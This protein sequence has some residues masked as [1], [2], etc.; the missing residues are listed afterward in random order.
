M[1]SVQKKKK[2]CTPVTG[3]RTLADIRI[4]EFIRHKYVTVLQTVFGVQIQALSS[5]PFL[6]RINIAVQVGVL[7]R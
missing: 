7:T 5:P 4:S 2:I 1:I 3:H 6:L